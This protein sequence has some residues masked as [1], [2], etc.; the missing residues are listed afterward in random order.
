MRWPGTSWSRWSTT[1]RT[2]SRS[3]CTPTTPA[4]GSD[5]RSWT[6]SPGGRATRG[7]AAQTLTTF[8]DVAWNGPYYA[9]LG[10]TVVPAEALTPG[11]RELRAAETARGLDRWPRVVM[12]RPLD[13]S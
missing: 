8:R 6:T 11:L 4:A 3:A 13:P 2:S 5:G 9:R 10:F 12:S 1:A 7:L